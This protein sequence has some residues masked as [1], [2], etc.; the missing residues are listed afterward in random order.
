MSLS[1]APL[2]QELAEDLLLETESG[3]QIGGPYDFGD[4]YN[5][6]ETVRPSS[7]SPSLC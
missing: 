7:L 3:I 6:F 5:G 1:P 4:C 2:P